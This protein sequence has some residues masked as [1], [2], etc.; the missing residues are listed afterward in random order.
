MNFEADRQIVLFSNFQLKPVESCLAPFLYH[1]KTKP[2]AVDN[3]GQQRKPRIP[4]KAA[5][6]ATGHREDPA[7]KE[8]VKA[9]C[10]MLDSLSYLY[11]LP[12]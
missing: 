11:V 2:V 7:N 8:I 12:L 4:G 3:P 5:A 6:K 10:S 1:R 9:D